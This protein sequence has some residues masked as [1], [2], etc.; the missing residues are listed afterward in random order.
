MVSDEYGRIGYTQ[1]E[2]IEYLKINP[3]FDILGL[4]LIDGEK[5]EMA[6]DK[7]YLDV[8]HINLWNDRDNDIPVL[9]YHKELQNT[10][11]MPEE[12]L[13]MNIEEYIKS[14][15]NSKE[16]LERVNIE[17]DLYKKFNLI[18]ILKYLKYL[19]DIADQNNIV[20]GIGRGSS[21]ASYC[22]YLMKIHRV[23]SIRFGLD[24]NEFLRD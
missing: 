3:N 12:Y 15:C 14:K 9:E 23:N 7:T 6:R 8:P 5:Y 18:N 17:L 11:L 2:V 20:W 13:E 19:R 1:Q 4:F 21:C 10:W 22:L 24:I 16:E